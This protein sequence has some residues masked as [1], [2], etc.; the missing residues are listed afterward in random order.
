VPRLLLLVAVEAA[1]LADAHHLARQLHLLHRRGDLPDARGLLCAQLVHHQPGGGLLIGEPPQLRDLLG[2]GFLERLEAHLR[3][4]L[5]EQCG[6]LRHQR[7]HPHRTADGVVRCMS[8]STGGC[9][10]N[11]AVTAGG[12]NAQAHRSGRCR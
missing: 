2:D 5:V 9:R 8:A 11:L 12:R 6:Q 3:I 10:L 1:Q 4:Q 7:W